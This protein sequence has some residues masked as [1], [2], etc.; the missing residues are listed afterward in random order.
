VT[1]YRKITDISLDIDTISIYRKKTISKVP[2]RYRYI[3]IG[4]ISTIF[5]ICRP[6]S[7]TWIAPNHDS[8]QRRSDM[9]HTVVLANNIMPTP[10]VFRKR[11]PDGAT[12]VCNGRH[13]IAAYYPT[14]V[15]KWCTRDLTYRQLQVEGRTL[16]EHRKPAGQRVTFYR[17][18]TQRKSPD[19]L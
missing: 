14:W 16:A 17:Y 18:N 9:D 2:I 15:Y 10:T 8:P 13:L 11:L 5:S 6:T 12:T 1:K 7:S 19:A 4:D 3:D